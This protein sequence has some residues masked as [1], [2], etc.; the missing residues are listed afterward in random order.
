MCDKR[1]FCDVQ[2]VNKAKTNSLTFSLPKGGTGRHRHCRWVKPSTSLTKH[3]ASKLVNPFVWKYVSDGGHSTEWKVP[4]WCAQELFLS[5]IQEIPFIRCRF[6]ILLVCM[7]DSFYF[8]SSPRCALFFV[9]QFRKNYVSIWRIFK[10][11][12]NR[13][14]NQTSSVRIHWILSQWNWVRC[15]SWVQIHSVNYVNTW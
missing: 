12:A 2:V 10:N 8:M 3:L 6:L 9:M 1:S 7:A 15:Q 5:R 13:L 14:R 11:L 4:H